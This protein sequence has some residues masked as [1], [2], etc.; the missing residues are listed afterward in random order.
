[1]NDP[2]ARRTGPPQPAARLDIIL[3]SLADDKAED[4][5][6]IDL[7]GKTSMADYMVVATAR[8]KRHIA[9]LADHL[10]ERLKAAGMTTVP[11]EGIEQ[12]DWVLL[13]AGDVVVHLFQAELR[14][15]YNVEKMWAIPAPEPPD[16]SSDAARA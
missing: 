12:G 9:T 6:T 16:E 1:L 11:V 4:V 7:A 13:D 8:S 5:V 2:R 15:F 14:D 3:A 10:R